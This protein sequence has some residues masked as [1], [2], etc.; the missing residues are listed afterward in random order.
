MFQDSSA[1]VTEARP[2]V[3]GIQPAGGGSEQ[4]FLLEATAGV[5]D[6][7]L[8]PSWAGEW[9]PGESLG[10]QNGVYVPQM[11]ELK[12]GARGGE[13]LQVTQK[14]GSRAGAAPNVC[15]TSPRDPGLRHLF[16]P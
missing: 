6:R 1:L 12:P 14:V 11:T 2:P 9:E 8:R 13:D 4:S 7:C 5:A 16:L 10:R 3:D 15:P